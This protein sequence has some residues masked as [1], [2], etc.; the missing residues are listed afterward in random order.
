[1][2]RPPTIPIQP[3]D[4]QRKSRKDGSVQ[5]GAFM[6]DNLI[7]L[8]RDLAVDLDDPDPERWP[9]SEIRDLLGDEVVPKLVEALAHS[10][11]LIRKMA[12]HA[13]G[14]LGWPRNGSLDV[15]AAVPSLGKVLDG[16]PDPEVRMEAAEAL[17]HIC[18]HEAAV[19]AFLDGLHKDVEFRRWSAMMLGLLGE[20]APCAVQPLTDALD[21]VDLLVRRYAADSLATHGLG[22][23]TALPSLQRLF[24][25]DERTRFIA[26][27]AILT[28]DPSRA[29]ELCPILAEALESRSSLTR[30]QATHA[31][32]EI[33]I[34][35][36]IA[37]PH[38]IQALDD[39]V[40]TVRIAAL[41]SLE[42]LGPAAA[43]AVEVLIQ[44]FRGA[45]RDGDFIFVRGSA[46]DVLAAIGEEAHT[47]VFFLLE[48]LQEPGDDEV[49][50]CFRL[51][52]A[53][54]LWFISGEPDHLLARAM[55]L[56]DNSDC[57]LR[58]RA[59]AMLGELGAAG[60]AAIP[61]LRRLVRD[62]HPTVRRLA[63]EALKKI[64]AKA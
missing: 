51:Q 26:A 24:G 63:A 18:E 4:T 13:L 59:A 16:D 8:L 50:V 33:P 43:P 60:R 54:A 1:M 28:I 49:T 46:A 30:L 55:E 52:V 61:D 2:H 19:Q 58:G 7:Q 34:A 38:L 22:A 15:E 35:G 45:G 64:G 5:L 48:S 41:M 40:I 39:E 36:R 62:E 31:F 6:N 12:A 23:T 25:E 10:D 47:A 20:K 32:G 11:P 3:G 57:S 44:I 42:K 29:E 9:L 17:W 53:R 21:D 14:R 37:V 27:K 56:L